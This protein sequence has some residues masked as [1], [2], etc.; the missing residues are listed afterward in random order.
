MVRR[1]SI[2]KG[3]SEEERTSARHYTSLAIGAFAALATLTIVIITQ[4]LYNYNIVTGLLIIMLFV[5]ILGFWGKSIYQTLI[6]YIEKRKN[7]ELARFYFKEFKKL[8]IRF[9]E[10][11]ENRSDNIQLVMHD[12]K[13]KTEFSQINV[14]WPTFIQERYNYYDE[15]LN[16]FDGTK[17]N[18]VALAKEFENILYMYNELYINDPVKSIRNVGRDKVPLQ[19]KESY[20]KARLK[21]IDFLNDY[22]NFAKIANEDFKEKE[23]TYSLVEGYGLGGSIVFRDF[24]DFPE[25]L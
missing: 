19:N 17:D 21:Y 22:K 4:K 9:K 2:E 12:I 14:I 8:V 24:F 3:K 1:I 18:L 25:E 7:D 20:N 23:E 13:N 16:E 10:F 5:L 11:T 15:R 6:G